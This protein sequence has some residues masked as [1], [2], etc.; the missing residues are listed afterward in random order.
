[1]SQKK[2]LQEA[3]AILV[4]ECPN[5]FA[6]HER[7]LIA[8]SSLINPHFNFIP[9]QENFQKAQSRIKECIDTISKG[10]SEELFKDS[11]YEEVFGNLAYHFNHIAKDCKSLLEIYHHYLNEQPQQEI[12]DKW[13][14]T[15]HR[16]LR[17]HGLKT[18]NVFLLPCENKTSSSKPLSDTREN[19]IPWNGIDASG[20]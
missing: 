7:A 16:A 20:P 2:E 6:D 14:K 1:M 9:W 11:N 5:L 17:L 13:S 10:K 15:L 3:F 19:L 8:Y 4:D 18:V 12:S